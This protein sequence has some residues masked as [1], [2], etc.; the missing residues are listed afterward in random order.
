M[1]C[2]GER[3]AAAALCSRSLPGDDVHMRVRPCVCVCVCLVS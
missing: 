1:Y 3:A 2:D